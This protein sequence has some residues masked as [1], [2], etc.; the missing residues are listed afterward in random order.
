MDSTPLVG[1]IVLN[2]NGARCLEA[3]LASL[4]TLAYQQFF[5]LVVD[6]DSSDGS[7]D[8]AQAHFPEY[9]FLKNSTN[10]G[11]AAGMNVGMREALKR[12]AERIWLLNN[13][14]RVTAES[15]SLLVEESRKRGLLSPV[16][17]EKSGQP[18]FEKGA[19]SFLRMRA[20][21]VTPTWRERHADSYESEFLT[22]CA[23]LITK[24]VIER[25]GYLDEQFFLYYEDADYS[26]RARKA[27]FP[28]LV[29]PKA[30]VY[31]DEQSRWNSTKLYHLVLSGL[32][33]FHKQA[34]FWQKPY[35]ALYG[36][37]RRVK[38]RFDLLRSKEGASDV[39]R[40][41]YHFSHDRSTDH[42][43]HF[44]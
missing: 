27:G 31:H 7:S 34:S 5:V 21:H 42:I 33:F 26:F 29:V 36:T 40:A 19:I 8:L 12:G 43:T 41:Y 37:I 24:D 9:S 38:N 1:I 11:F 16:I 28:V 39:R 23:L 14:A 15:L 3:C 2:Y 30:I 13:D 18:W 6:N 10:L 35:L 22:G 20:I 44:R 17:L 32:I 4:Q 25:I